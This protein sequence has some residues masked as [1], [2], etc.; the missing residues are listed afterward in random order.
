ECLHAEPQQALN[1]SPCCA[2]GSHHWPHTGIIA[3]SQSK[4]LF[5]SREIDYGCLSLLRFGFRGL[6]LSRHPVLVHRQR[7]ELR[8]CRVC[9][10]SIWM[11][12][13][14]SVQN[15]YLSDLNWGIV[16]IGHSFG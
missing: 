16:W 7:S 1:H 11:G 13:L 10:S 3:R 12:I 9:K 4:I 6:K 15:S 2:A 8:G 14:S 5:G